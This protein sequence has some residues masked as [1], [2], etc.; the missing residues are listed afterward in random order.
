[1]RGDPETIGLKPANPDRVHYVA[2]KDLP[3]SCPMPGTSLWSSHQRV[4][5]PVQES[6]RAQCPYCGTVY[7]L[8][9]AAPP[10]E[11][12]AQPNVEI[13]NFHAR[14]IESHHPAE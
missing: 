11:E 14:A 1:M 4:Y 5:L 8:T 7:I 6:G 12:I 9:D 2:W 13:E 10:T 3:L